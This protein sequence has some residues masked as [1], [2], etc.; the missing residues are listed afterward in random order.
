M[1]CPSATFVNTLHETCHRQRTPEP[2]AR[3]AM[4]L[5]SVALG[6]L[7]SLTNHFTGQVLAGDT[8]AA[9][10]GRHGSPVSSQRL[11]VSRPAGQPGR[12]C[13]VGPR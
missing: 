5:N 11:C 9:G 13:L 6:A 8:A 7:I 4:V 10:H 3:L 12:E 1:S 2:G